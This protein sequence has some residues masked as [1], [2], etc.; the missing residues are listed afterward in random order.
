MANVLTAAEAAVVL[1]CDETDAAM[2]AVLPQIDA[3]LWNA[4]GHNWAADS[5]IEPE[6]KAAA[7]I[8]LVRWYEDPGR[9]SDTPIYGITSHLIQLESKAQR[10]KMIHGGFSAGPLSLSGVKVG[11]KVA[12]VTGIVGASGDQSALFESSITVDGQIQQVS[13][14]NLYGKIYRA[15]V[16]P[17]EAL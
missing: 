8:M 16:I 6:A 9:I 4:T 11:D 14:A 7:Q 12:S 1:R 5:T 15:Y 3:Y 2:L 17:L 13:G 10:Y